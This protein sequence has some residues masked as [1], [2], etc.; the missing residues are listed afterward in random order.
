VGANCQKNNR[1]IREVLAE[2]VFTL[3]DM[4]AFFANHEDNAKIAVNAGASAPAQ[5]QLSADIAKE[6]RVIWC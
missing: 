2:T 5:I 6:F 4:T 1:V 3:R